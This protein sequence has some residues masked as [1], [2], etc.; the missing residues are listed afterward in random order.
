MP[1]FGGILHAYLSDSEFAFLSTGVKVQ[2]AKV[3][4]P[5]RSTTILRQVVVEC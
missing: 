1:A 4:D 2:H 3:Q 5:L